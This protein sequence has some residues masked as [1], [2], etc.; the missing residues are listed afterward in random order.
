MILFWSRLA[1][2]DR[3]LIFDYIEAHN[4]EAAETLD[5]RIVIAIN[6]L[7]EFPESGRPGRING[8]RELVISG[9]P[10]IAAYTLTPKGIRILRILHAVQQWPGAF[11][12][13]K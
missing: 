1:L 7:N 5:Q 6:R 8:T 9:T 11:Q 13:E 3:D 10:Y 12:K 2:D 4:P